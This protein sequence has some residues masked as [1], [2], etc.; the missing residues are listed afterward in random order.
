M[1]VIGGEVRIVL[2]SSIVFARATGLLGVSSV[3][4]V[5]REVDHRCLRRV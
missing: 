3:W 4:E 1:V 5:P 2:T